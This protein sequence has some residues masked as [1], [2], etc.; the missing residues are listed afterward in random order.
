MDYS[1]IQKHTLSSYLLEK[2]EPVVRKV[3]KISIPIAIIIALTFPFWGGEFYG[4][5]IQ[6]RATQYLENVPTVVVT[7]TLYNWQPVDGPSYA[8]LIDQEVEGV[9]AGSRIYLRGSE[10]YG[11]IGGEIVQVKGKFIDDYIEYLSSAGMGILGGDED[12]PVI[13][14][15]D[16]TIIKSPGEFIQIAGTVHY[17]ETEEGEI[18]TFNPEPDELHKLEKTGKTKAIL[19]D[20]SYNF[21]E[22]LD[23]GFVKYMTGKKIS[24]EG[25]IKTSDGKYDVDPYSNLPIIA[26]KYAELYSN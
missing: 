11:H 10:I 12:S 26:V 13:L 1:V 15:D 17:T 5:I 9:D 6:F 19:E 18:F 23:P 2:L 25:F 7:G 16:V 21:S 8:I 24:V 3:I 14:V 4:D 22:I 20:S